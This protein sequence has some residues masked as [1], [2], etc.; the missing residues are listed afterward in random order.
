MAST[1]PEPPANPVPRGVD[2]IVERQI[3]DAQER[4]LFDNLPGAGRPLP[5][6]GER[7]DENWWLRR[8][9]LREGVSGV[10]FLP[11]ALALR[12][13]VEDLPEAVAGLTAETTVRAVVAALNDRIR[14]ALARPA[15]GPSMTLMEVE[16][17]RVVFEW[18]LAR[19][20]RGDLPMRRNS[21][22]VAAESSSSPRRPWW[23]RQAR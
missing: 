12:R 14:A 3:R 19:I 16:V 17:E 1:E 4:G 20:G 21:T 23:R 10:P 18:R 6:L 11:P 8:H 22:E 13:A 15:E 2:G 5:D 9:V 7:R